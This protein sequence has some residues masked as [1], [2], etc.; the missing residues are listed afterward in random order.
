MMTENMVELPRI[1]KSFSIVIVCYTF[2]RLSFFFPRTTSDA[3]ID[4]FCAIF[5]SNIGQK[6]NFNFKTR[7]RRKNCNLLIVDRAQALSGK[8]DNQLPRCAVMYRYRSLSARIN[9]WCE[10]W[11]RKQLH[12]FFILMSWWTVISSAE[13][14]NSKDGANMT[15][16]PFQ[17]WSEVEAFTRREKNLHETIV[18]VAKFRKKDFVIHSNLSAMNIEKRLMLVQANERVAPIMMTINRATRKQG[19][20][21]TRM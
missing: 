21:L 8:L 3:I 5:K 13:G 14:E 4:N 2:S 17:T 6:G 7:R 20:R 11:E 1:Y 18:R 9:G 19:N 15:Q 12:C 10:W 16:R